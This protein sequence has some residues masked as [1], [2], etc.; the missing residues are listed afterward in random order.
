[1]TDRDNIIAILQAEI[2]YWD[3]VITE[4]DKHPIRNATQRAQAVGAC[5]ALRRIVSKL[6]GVPVEKRA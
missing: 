4:H 6:S 1:M 3:G 5:L 2:A